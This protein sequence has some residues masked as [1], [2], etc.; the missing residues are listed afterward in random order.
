MGASTGPL[1]IFCGKDSMWVLEWIYLWD[2]ANTM[3]YN[4]AVK[5]NFNLQ[6]QV[7]P[8]SMSKN[9]YNN[10][11]NLKKSCRLVWKLKFLL[12]KSML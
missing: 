3:W 7:F 11:W 10:V 9:R 1:R 12:F 5:I 6:K 8:D 4:Y 2:L